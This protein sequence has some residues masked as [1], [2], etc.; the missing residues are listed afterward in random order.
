VAAHEAWRV[1]VRV[2]LGSNLA[3]RVRFKN[4]PLPTISNMG[5]LKRSHLFAGPNQGAVLSDISMAT[6]LENGDGNWEAAVTIIVD[7]WPE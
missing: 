6:A 5:V 7:P 2:Q 1:L 4:G 3:S